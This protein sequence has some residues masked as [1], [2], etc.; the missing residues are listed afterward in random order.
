MAIGPLK[1]LEMVSGQDERR[2]GNWV[3]F[4]SCDSVGGLINRR[5]PAEQREK[6]ELKPLE[7]QNAEEFITREVQSEV[8][9]A[10]IEP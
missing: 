10:E 3:F 2:T 6:G 1:I 4:S 9:S 7:L 8:R 5:G